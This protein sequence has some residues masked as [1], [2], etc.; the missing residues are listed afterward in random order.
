MDGSE[1]EI[2]PVVDASPGQPAEPGAVESGGSRAGRKSREE[3]V[4]AWLKANGLETVPA[5]GDGPAGDEVADGGD[6]DEAGTRMGLEMV[7]DSVDSCAVAYVGSKAERITGNAEAGAKFGQQVAV[8]EKTR[9]VIVNSG[10]E[11]CR[12]HQVNIG[13]ECP[14]IAGVTQWAYQVRTAI[15]ELD[16][17]ARWQEEQRAKKAQ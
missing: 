9:N 14:L 2:P 15:K 5:G 17:I 3:E 4:A 7:V 6:F 1:L 13:P 16:A 8:K 12:K 11:L 10:V